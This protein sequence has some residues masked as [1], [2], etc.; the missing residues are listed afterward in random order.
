MTKIEHNYVAKA[1]G[2]TNSKAL[3]IKAMCA[4]CMGCTE[5]YREPGYRQAIG[6]C[7]ST[8]C[9]LYNFR[10]FRDAKESHRSDPEST[11]SF[12]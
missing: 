9:P 1:I 5:S 6:N 7:S 12:E 3:A 11:I 10:P 4:H 8:K 2:N